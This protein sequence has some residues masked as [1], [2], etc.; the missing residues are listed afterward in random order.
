MSWEKH[1]QFE[2]EFGGTHE[3]REKEIIDGS[4]FIAVKSYKAKGKRVSTF[5]IKT[6]TE[7]EPINRE[8][9]EQEKL[10]QIGDSSDLPDLT[11]VAELPDATEIL[12]VTELPE[13]SV[14]NSK[15]TQAAQTEE[16]ELID[17]IP[18]EIIR[19]GKDGEPGQMEL[20]FE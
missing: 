2:I 5:E 16:I 1:P 17:D 3:G 13:S 8:D 4:E 10:Q 11:G 15:E 18:F 12:E 19:P 14:S 7:I 20:I 6:I 9:D